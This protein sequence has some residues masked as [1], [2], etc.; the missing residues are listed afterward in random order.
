LFHYWNG[1]WMWWAS[2]T[3]QMPFSTSHLFYPAGI[4]LAYHNFAWLNIAAWL[5][6]RP[7]VGGFAAYN[8]S[9]LTSLALCG[10][11]AFVLTRDLTG[12]GR[13]AFLAGLIYQCWPFRLSQLDHPNLISTQ[14][15]PLFLLFLIRVVRRGRWQDGVLAGVFL[16]LTGYTRWQ[17]LIPAAIVGGV[18]LLCTL[19][20]RWASRRRWA[21]ALLLAGG[22]AALLLAPPA[23]LL[24]GQQ[25]IA[26][27]DLVVEG[28]EATMQ[29]DLLA[30]L[31]PSGSHSILGS[32]T[33]PAYDRYYADRSGGRR[34][35][36]YVGV[37]I[38]ALALL[39]VRKVRGAALPWVAVALVL[40][41]LALGPVL[42]VGGRLY[43]A[44]PMP[45]RLLARSFVVRLLRFPDRFN[46]F[47]ALPAAV[48]AAYGIAGALARAH[49]R[50][51]WAAVAVSCMLGGVILFEYLAIPVPFQHPQLS[52][53]Y[54]ELADERGDFA[55]LNLPINPQQS[56]LYMFAQVTHHRP[57]LQGHTSRLPHGAYAYLDGHPWL[58]ELRWSGEMPPGLTD[59]SRQLTS[60]AEDDV[61]Y[62]IL[63]KTLAGPDRL[64]RWQRYLLI[65]PRFED[66]QIAIYATTPLAGLD[67]TLA[68]ELTPGIG[69]IRVIT[70]T[71]CLN[72][73]RVLEVDVGWATTAAPGRDLHVK[74]ALVGEEGIVRQEEVFPLSPVWPTHEWPANAVA[75]GYYTLR[76]DPSFP[77]GAYTGTLAL[78]D[79]VTGAMQ[80]HKAVLGQ[81]TV[82]QFPCTF[83]I[84]PD[85]ARA[86]RVNALFGD[87]LRLLGYRLSQEDDRL[88]LT[89]Y[90]RAER[91]METAYKIFV[92][93]FDPATQVPVAQD[94]AMPRRWAY[95]T[96]FWGPGEVVTD[97]I[98]I[99]LEGVPVGAYGVAL[100]VYDPA[101]M[102]RLPVVDGAGQPQPD[103]RLVL[104]GEV[105]R[106]EEHKP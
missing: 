61:R 51:R 84:P 7:W 13:A 99:S 37:T 18:Y 59:V 22:V 32:L 76:A 91:R 14:S 64:A 35:S 70:S 78:V 105:V 93:V 30:Y 100:G 73:G 53:H 58:R 71:G 52:P 40:I 103:G 31:T 44:V 20:G 15:I 3:G 66:E 46:M 49:R 29:S 43:P 88:T 65:A 28:E 86:V 85:A 50:G 97:V 34:F 38:L 75:W 72:P 8:L 101:T 33:Q 26:P 45:Y 25:R 55:V 74:L 41:L 106:V 95:P 82:S 80:G 94:D 24:A 104:P 89:L 27:V 63:H 42:R 96:T 79:P 98:S 2:I 60:L 39:G 23:L 69:L 87:D 11:A 36:P 19:P 6:L 83:A 68:D 57:V 1:W 56:K 10:F 12:D 81:V 54:D 9:L 90:W 17:L 67:F 5:V 4:S 92:H 47:L 16:A 62:L 102:G 21:L 77:T 48:L